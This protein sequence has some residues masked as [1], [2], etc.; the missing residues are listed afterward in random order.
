MSDLRIP[1]TNE[2]H[3]MEG[4]QGPIIVRGAYNDRVDAAFAAGDADK[5]LAQPW[6]AVY[7]YVS[8]SFDMAAAA[9]A[10]IR[11]LAGRRFDATIVDIEEGD[12]D[13]QAREH[14]WLT[15]MADDPARDWAYSGDYFARSHGL[16]PEWI[17]AYQQ[18]EPTAAHTLWQFSDAYQFPGMSGPC[19]ASLFH[20]T[21]DDLIAL[22]GGQPSS[23]PPKEDDVARATYVM[24]KGSGLVFAHFDDGRF[25]HVDNPGGLGFTTLEDLYGRTLG[26]QFVA[27][28]FPA[29]YHETT[30]IDD[31]SG[32]TRKVLVLGAGT[33]DLI[34]V[35]KG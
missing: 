20:G 13:Q 29:G 6:R 35:P 2:F 19:D 5:A 28:D 25:V 18:R 4:Y 31:G 30:P 8:K 24:R 12:G 10:F 14:A 23:T 11:I 1:D 26:V 21:L 15:V 34:G 16:A 3:R 9:H 7:Q 22:T 27:D 32:Q 17:A 33:A